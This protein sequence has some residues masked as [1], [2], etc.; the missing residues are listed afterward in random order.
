MFKHI[1][2]STKQNKNKNLKG[3]PASENRAKQQNKIPIYSSDEI[4]GIR[5]ACEL[6]REVLDIAGKLVKVGIT[7]EEIDK[8]V[9]KA[10][11]ERN[12]YPS[13]LNYYKFPKSCCTL[14]F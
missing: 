2:K 8:Q 7:T 13:P 11:I 10:C 5:R 12:C 9:H 1:N 6:G 14:V 4:L 3:F